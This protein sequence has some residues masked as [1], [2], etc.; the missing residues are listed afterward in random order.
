MQIKKYKL[1]DSG[2]K[3]KLEQ[4]G[5]YKI[6]RPCPQA[7]WKPFSPELWEKYDVEFIRDSSEKGK[8]DWKIPKGS[9]QSKW[10]VTNQ[11]ELIWNIEPNEF[12]NIGIFPEHW[13]YTQKILD[14]LKSKRSEILS[15][16]CYSG[17]NSLALVK[18]GH[19]LTMVDS[20]KVAITHLMD[21]V[22]VNELNQSLLRLIVED[23][24][25]FASREQRRDKKYDC[26]LIDAPSF[27]RGTKGE[28]FSIEDGLIKLIEVSKSLIHENSI[29]LFTL[30]SPR[31]TAL[32]L[33]TMFSQAFVDKKVEVSEII[34]EMESSKKG[35]PSGYLVFIK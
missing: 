15:L 26:L 8:W 24:Y 30:H 28:V 12:G 17:S 32:G 14:N 1:I 7:M 6:I 10:T 18:A 23:A 21:N 13:E 25:K 22:K 3:R 11:D 9:I 34:V 19:K 27:G 31:F 20:S 33:E 2:D 16:F 5:K 29:L 35:L 4:V